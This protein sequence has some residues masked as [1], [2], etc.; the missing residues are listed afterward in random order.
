MQ[1]RIGTFQV[2]PEKLEEVE[3]LFQHQV[4]PAFSRHRGFI[5]YT[6]YVDRER[7]R[8]VGISLWQTR[9]DLDASAEAA[10]QARNA[11][12]QI[13]AQTVG[14]PQM[15]EMAFD[16]RPQGAAPSP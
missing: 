13:G 15:L 10:L 16:A 5:G 3:R 6:A 9:Q 7:G 4:V 8:F 12:A 1:A 2:S 14:E 11:A